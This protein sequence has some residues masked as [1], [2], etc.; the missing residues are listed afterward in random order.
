MKRPAL[1]SLL[2]PVAALTLALGLAAPALAAGQPLLSLDDPPDDAFGPGTYVLPSSGEFADGDFDLRRFAVLLDGEDA[3]FEITL[4]AAVRRPQVTS[5]DGSPEVPLSN[6]I[7]LQ[8]IDIYLDTNPGSSEGS[9]EGLPGRRIRFA[10]GR[11]WKRAV[12]LTP[13]P[14]PTRSVVEEALHAGAA[15][16]FFAEALQQRGRTLI[17]RVPVL[18]LGGV[19][20]RDW[21]Y[22]VQV[23]GA[24]WDRSFGLADRISGTRALDAFTLPVVSV[25][26]PYAFGGAPEGNAHPRVLDVLLPPGVDQKK[27]LGSSDAKTGAWARVPFVYPEAP[28]AIAP[29]A[30]APVASAPAAPA[31][32]SSAGSAPATAAPAPTAPAAPSK[33]AAPAGLTVTDIAGNLVTV[34]GP[35]AGLKPMQFGRVLD[36]DGRIVA[37]LLITKVLEGGVLAQPVASREKILR[38]ARVVFDPE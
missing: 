6:G 5:R 18:A 19:P 2:L 12:V 26:E 14:G 15:H 36:G 32:V 7:Y 11:T 10:D 1:P 3:V 37:H 25:P 8:N 16:V 22:S 24:R 29:A 20:R 9:A 33:S 28:R 38:G 27:V 23:S 35:V 21:G 17:V 13:Q 34:S 31:P 30:A 4:G